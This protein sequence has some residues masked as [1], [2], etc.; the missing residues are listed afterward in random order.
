VRHDS[1]ALAYLAALALPVAVLLADTAHAD[2]DDKRATHHSRHNIPIVLERQLRDRLHEELIERG[3][4]DFRIDKRHGIRY[5]RSLTFAG[6]PIE[7]RLHGPVQRRK[8]FGLG[9]RVDF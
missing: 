1:G 9:F 4:G 2:D 8:S 6:R 7:V 3:L 5:R